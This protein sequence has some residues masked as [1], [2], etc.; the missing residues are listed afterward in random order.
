MYALLRTFFVLFY[1]FLA[2]FIVVNE[3][4]SKH[5]QN[6]NSLLNFHGKTLI[7]MELEKKFQIPASIFK[8]F[9][10]LQEPC[11]MQNGGKELRCGNDLRYSQLKSYFYL[12]SRSRIDFA[13]IKNPHF[14]RTGNN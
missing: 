14:L 8:E 2:F 1:L 5:S 4:N 6:S 11:Y 13:F 7:F 12:Q 9:K 10:G 3:V